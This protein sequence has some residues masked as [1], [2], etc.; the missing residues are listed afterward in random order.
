MYIMMLAISAASLY[1]F[2]LPVKDF[3][4]S[5]NIAGNNLISRTEILT[6]LENLDVADKDFYEL[7]ARDIKNSLIKR[8]LVKNVKVRARLFNRP[9]YTIKIDEE[10]PWAIY[11][12]QVFSDEAKVIVASLANAKL[13][14]SEAA[15]KLFAESDQG[16]IKISSYGILEQKQIE[17]IRDLSQIIKTNLALIHPKQRL[18]KINI[19]HEN[20][21]TISSA[22]LDFKLGSLNNNTLAKAKRLKHL[23]SKVKEIGADEKRAYIDLSMNTDEV[24]IGQEI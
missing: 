9:H 15:E 23:L 1:S 17:M 4:D 5:L 16:L 18:E 19:D 8:P 7:N 11:R 6:A 20:N 21:L 3:A 24:I 10:K 13:F 2:K 14:S 12:G 22:K